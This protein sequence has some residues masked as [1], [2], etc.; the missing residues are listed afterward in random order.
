M[1]D[2]RISEKYMLTVREA[3]AYFGIGEKKLRRMID[4]DIEHRFHLMNGSKIMIR[5]ADLEKYLNSVS[6][7]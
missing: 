3:V 4:E 5:R 7:I 1:G 6:A 2:L